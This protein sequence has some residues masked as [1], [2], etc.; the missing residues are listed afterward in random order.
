MTVI[1]KINVKKNEKTTEFDGYCRFKID[2]QGI[3]KPSRPSLLLSK[4]CLKTPS[5]TAPRFL[6][7]LQINQMVHNNPNYTIPE[8]ISFGKIFY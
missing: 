1:Q 2:V 6:P 8:V 5:D 3:Q 7:S 4:I